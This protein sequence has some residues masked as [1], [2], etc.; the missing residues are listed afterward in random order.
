MAAAGGSPRSPPASSDG[1]AGNARRGYP[2]Q[3]ERTVPQ[4]LDPEPL[5]PE[6]AQKVLRR[7]AQLDR[8]QAPTAPVRGLEDEPRLDAAELERIAAESGLSP[9]AV[10]RALRELQGGALLPTAK[11]APA[12]AARRAF[13]E[14]PEVIEGRLTAALL[15]SGLSPVHVAPHETRWKPAT[16]LGPTL[17]RAVNFE[18]SGA[19]LGASISSSVYGVA[20][21]RSSAELRGEVGD[22]SLPIATVTGLLL[23][24]PAGIA[25]LI[26]VA[27]GLSE[28]FARQQGLALLL[29]AASWAA[30][31]WAISRGVGRRRVRKLQRALERVLAQ[32]GG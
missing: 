28:G 17:R 5:D 26:I 11:S 20:G 12:A 16:G 29:V 27:I 25:S 14:R 18:G 3:M 13:S 21:E 9:E 6:Q 22:L 32:I 19:F 1:G 2:L 4:P 15:R 24:F 7:A 8:E 23:A 31:T 10:R 30:L